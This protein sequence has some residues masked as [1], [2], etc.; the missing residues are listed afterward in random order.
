MKWYENPGN[1]ND[2]FTAARIRL[3]RNIEGYK[4]PGTMSEEEAGELLDRMKTELSDVGRAIGMNFRYVDLTEATETEKEAWRERRVITN[5][6][7]DG[8]NP[9]GFFVS[10]D[11]STVIALNGDDHIRIHCYGPGMNLNRLE[12]FCTALD[13]AVNRHFSYAFDE[14]YGYLTANPTSMGTG[15]KASAI[16]HLPYLAEGKTFRNLLNEVGR[17]GIRV[18]GLMGEGTEN[19]GSFFEVSNQK[20]LGQSEEEILSLVYRMASHLAVNERKVRS[21]AIRDKR[22]LMEDQVYKAYGVIRYARQLSQREALSYLSA[23]RSGL[24]EGLLKS[25][26]PLN[27]FGIIWDCRD[28]SIRERRIGQLSQEECNVA[29]AE[30]IRARLP[31]LVSLT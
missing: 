15:L 9:R 13:D 12:A 30:M 24:C 28:A 10:E 17:M 21:M 25:E 23:I 29:R 4:F 14:K 26:Q 31:E 18:R 16:L 6:L 27:I 11:E 1:G 3:V 2:V 20:T 19:Y 5:V 7:V 8:T 22:V